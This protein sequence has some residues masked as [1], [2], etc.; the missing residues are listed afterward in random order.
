MPQNF[1]ELVW[2]FIIYAFLGWCTEVAYAALNTGRFVNRGFLNGPYCPIYGCGVV[3]VVA[4]LTPIQ[5]SLL[6]LFA[7]SLV[8]TSVLEYLTGLVLEKVFRNKWW[9]YS[10]EP[11]NI[12]GYVCLKF[13]I[14]WGLACTFVMKLVHPVIYKVITLV[15]FVAGVVILVIIMIGFTVDCCVTVATI[16]KFNKQLRLM[17]EMAA[18]LHQL[19]DEIGEHIYENVSTAVEKS[20]QFQGEHAEFLQKVAEKR[21]DILEIPVVTKNKIKDQK[22]S[23]AELSEAAKVKLQDRRAE[24]EEL[25]Q[26][27]RALYEKRNIVFSRL[28]KAFPGMKSLHNNEHLQ[29]YKR[30]ISNLKK[31]EK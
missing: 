13:S 11:F 19:S 25:R 18:R 17:E 16:L 24:Y 10:N 12:Q 20:E 1:Y 6:L 2:I 27:Y 21:V 15:P 26:K 3:I 23:L 28:V 14:M 8:L 30:Y 9:D 29:E 31:K 7:G 22:Q 4:L 5:E